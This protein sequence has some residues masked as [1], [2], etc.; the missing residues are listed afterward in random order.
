MKLVTRTS[1]GP[2]GESHPSSWLLDFLDC[3]WMVCKARRSRHG[4]FCWTLRWSSSLFL[5]CY[6]EIV[7]R[8]PKAQQVLISSETASSEYEQTKQEVSFH[9]S[10]VDEDSH[11]H[12]CAYSG[13]ECGHLLSFSSIWT[14]DMNYVSLCNS[15][16]K[17]YR[18]NCVT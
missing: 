4:S 18:C 17:C 13:N 1:S 15:I 12:T 8:V 14:L 9:G 3:S 2:L 7:H 11:C 10:N 6:H 16:I 5:P